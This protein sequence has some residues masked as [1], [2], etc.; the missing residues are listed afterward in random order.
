MLTKP[1][2]WRWYRETSS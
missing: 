2:K 1:D